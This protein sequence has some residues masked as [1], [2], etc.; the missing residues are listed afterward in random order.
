MRW[1][2]INTA[3]IATPAVE[4]HEDRYQCDLM[5]EELDDSERWPEI[6][7][8]LRAKTRMLVRRH[9][10]RIERVAEALIA[11]QTLS[12]KQLDRLVG[13][14]VDD[15]KVNAPFILEMNRLK[16]RGH[17]HHRLRRHRR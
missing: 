14:S 5:A 16:R 4:S 3:N 6:E 9:R 10:A 1:R 7:P 17:C 12:R 11:K 15:V 13:R 2:Q 8:R